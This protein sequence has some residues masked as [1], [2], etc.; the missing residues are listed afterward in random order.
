LGAGNESEL[1]GL[2]H[3]AGDESRLIR[4]FFKEESDAGKV[5]TGDPAGGDDEVGLGIVGGDSRGGVLEFEAVPH[6]QRVP[7]RAILPEVLLEL[8]RG[9][10]LDMGDLGAE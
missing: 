1:V 2:G 6:D 5:G 4:C 9:L 10:G 7:L 8:G 3:R